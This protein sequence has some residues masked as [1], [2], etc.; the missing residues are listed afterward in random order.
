MKISTQTAE[1]YIWG[2]ACDGWHL[3]RSDS[4]SVIQERMPPGTAEQ[5]HFHERAQ[6][7]FFILAGEATFEVGEQSVRV[8]AQESL[9]IVPGIPHRI[10]NYGPL[11]LHFLVI[12]EPK[13]HG[14][15]VNE[16]S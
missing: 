6:Q 14:D 3:L 13:A 2:N 1:H 15:R 16:A 12:S 4:L 10:A 7:V 5:R 11:D 9:H 8:A